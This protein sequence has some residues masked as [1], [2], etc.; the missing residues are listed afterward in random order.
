MRV[1]RRL[2]GAF[3]AITLVVVIT[4]TA[5]TIL[6]DEPVG[7]PT[8]VTAAGPNVVQTSLHPLKLRKSSTILQRNLARP[9][10]SALR[11]PV[12]IILMPLV[13][14]GPSR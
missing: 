11:N 14:L 1:L 6:S 7:A 2:I 13:S 12:Q 4:V 3:T 5:A 8:T 10:H 9:G